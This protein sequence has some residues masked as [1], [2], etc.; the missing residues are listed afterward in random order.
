[1]QNDEDEDVQ[2]VENLLPTPDSN[3]QEVPSVM[4]H[5]SAAHSGRPSKLTHESQHII[6]QALTHGASFTSAAHQANISERT[7]FRWKA[8]GAQERDGIYHDF[9]TAVSQVVANVHHPPQNALSPM[10]SELLALLERAMAATPWND[11]KS[12]EQ[13]L[14][15]VLA[16][17]P[18]IPPVS[19][20]RG[21]RTQECVL[22]VEGMPIPS[23]PRYI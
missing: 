22:H 12:F 17:K 8:R 18:V 6:A 21:E 2:V 5:Q 9:V 19:P 15:Q 11:R 10:Q 7:I 16:Q 13:E 20:K 1:M 14:I 3:D 23:A 4:G